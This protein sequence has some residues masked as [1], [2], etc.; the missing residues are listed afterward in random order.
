MLTKMPNSVESGHDNKSGDAPSSPLPS[1]SAKASGSDNDRK[2]DVLHAAEDSGGPLSANGS[3]AK[4]DANGEANTGMGSQSLNGGYRLMNRVAGLA[5]DSLPKEQS[6]ETIEDEEPSPPDQQNSSEV[7]D[8]RATKAATD[9]ENSSDT[10]SDSELDEEVRNSNIYYPSRRLSLKERVKKSSKRVLQQMSYT[11]LMEDRMRDMEERLQFIENNG[12]QPE[13]P[14]PPP[15]KKK[16]P[17]DLIL[18]LKRMTLQEY[19]PI[20]PTQAT[21]SVVDQ[22]YKHMGRHEFPELLPFHLIDVVVSATYQPERLGKDQSQKPL[23]EP[24]ETPTPSVVAQAQSPAISDKQFPQAERI[25]I[26]SP[27]LLEAL[28]EITGHSFTMTRPYG[29]E[30]FQLLSQVILKPFKLFVTY[31]REIKD[32]ITRLENMHKPDEDETRTVALGNAKDELESSLAQPHPDGLNVPPETLTTST[33]PKDQN[34][35]VKTMEGYFNGETNEA[36]PLESKRCLAE[37]CVLRELLD[38]DLKPTF[39]LRKRIKDGNA[40]T[41]AF[42]DLWHLFGLGDEIVSND[43]NGHKQVYRVLDVSG[44]RPFLCSS[45]EA[46]M[47]LIVE[48]TSKGRDLPKFEILTYFYDS[49]GKDLGACQQILTIKWYDGNKAITSLPCYPIIY[50][51]NTSGSNPRDFFIERGRRYIELTRKNEVV[52]KR[53]DGLTLAMDELREEV[54]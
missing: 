29:Y 32:Y 15:E 2:E 38:N 53:Y 11:R 46:E 21:K 39:D 6:T 17:T 12:R 13:P 1:S 43:P 30:D 35:H 20:V 31:E 49:D 9:E 4:A 51:K 52:H 19:L 41:I 47:D 34:S 5:I 7:E 48:S 54:K 25:R 50:S 27:L 3:Y 40:R 45:L 8:A 36:K 37:L 10:A 26:N 28:E 24:L 33:K 18:G 42:Q 16:G 14:T 44:G 23:A 22:N